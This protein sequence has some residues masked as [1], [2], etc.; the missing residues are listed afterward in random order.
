MRPKVVLIVFGLALAVTLAVIVLHKP[1]PAT[2]GQV[3]DS[4]TEAAS[5]QS[6]SADPRV[7]STHAAQTA[8]TSPVAPL[9]SRP[10]RDKQAET[11][12]ILAKE[13]AT[14]IAAGVENVD[15][16]LPEEKHQAY[17]EARVLEIQDLASEE[18]NQSLNIILSELT[19]PDEEI[20]KAAVD[21]AIQFGSRDA[22]PALTVAAQQLD[23]TDERKA[24]KEAIEFLKL[25]H[26][27]ETNFP[28]ST[29]QNGAGK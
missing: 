8:S 7:Q 13:L 19:S 28:R 26:L 10:K 16:M 11:N 15:A 25:P 21:A 6:V 12:A 3:G 4:M 22:I 5:D 20:R 14:I 17:V 9:A 23:D 1:A 24:I 18:D 29:A 27:G 2:P